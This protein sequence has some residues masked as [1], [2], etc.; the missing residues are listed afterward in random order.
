M[1]SPMINA[2]LTAP[3]FA[4]APAEGVLVISPG[5]SWALFLGFMAVASAAMWFISRHSDTPK[6][7]T[8]HHPTPYREAA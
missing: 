3:L 4:A 5:L 2:A 8:K 6:S 1:M 7:G